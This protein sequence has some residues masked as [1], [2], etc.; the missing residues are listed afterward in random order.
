MNTRDRIF[1][2]RLF[3]AATVSVAVYVTFAGFLHW[4]TIPAMASL[5]FHYAIQP[6]IN[7]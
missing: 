4:A 7:S 6:W 2:Y 3:M 1:L 5:S